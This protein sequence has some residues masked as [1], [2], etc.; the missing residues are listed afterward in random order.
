MST[1]VYVFRAVHAPRRVHCANLCVEALLWSK[2]R[3]CCQTILVWIMLKCQSCRLGIWNGKHSEYSV[4]GLAIRLSG[5][6]AGQTAY[7]LAS[8]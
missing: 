2:P 7:T 6:G 4:A 3:A 8:G 1:A 5:L